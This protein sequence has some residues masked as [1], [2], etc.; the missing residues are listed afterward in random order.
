MTWMVCQRSIR[1][2]IS[3]K[4]KSF[5]IEMHWIH[6]NGPKLC[7]SLYLMPIFIRQ[8]SLMRTHLSVTPN[9]KIKKLLSL[10]TPEPAQ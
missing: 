10:Q 5:K 6:G 9:R 3:V 7:I 2:K 4:T 1:G 8:Y